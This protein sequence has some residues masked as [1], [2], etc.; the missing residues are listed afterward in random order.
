[1]VFNVGKCKVMHMGHQNPAFNYTMKGQV[2]EE[3][4]EEKDIGVM[5]TSNLKPTAQCARAAKMAQTVLGQLSR[6]FHYR[7]RHIFL[8]YKQ[9]V[10][11]HLEFSSP[12]WAPWTEGDRNCLEKVQQRAI[13]MVSGLKSNI[14]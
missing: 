12:P 3:T 11:P 6:T 7:D 5:V 2:L 14:F 10:R 9:Y 8:L 13:K 1:M 4:K